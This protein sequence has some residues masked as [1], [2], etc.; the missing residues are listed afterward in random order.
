MDQLAKKANQRLERIMHELGIVTQVIKTVDD[1][2]KEN[3][4][5]ELDTV[6]LEIGEMS[7][8]VPSF[9]VEAWTALAPTTP[10]PNAKMD[11]EVIPA[12]A[13]CQ[14]CHHKDSVRNLNFTCPKCNSLNFKIISGREFEI[15]QIIAK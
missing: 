14:D 4:L 7:D 13:E 9:I 11:I 10:Y 12:I 8:V 6:V 1:V 15:K 5:T 3:D 2:M